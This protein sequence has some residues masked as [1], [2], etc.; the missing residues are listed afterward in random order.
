MV[1]ER[2][3]NYGLTKL[4]GNFQRLREGGCRNALQITEWALYGK[5]RGKW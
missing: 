3:V 2:Y 5:R 1:K 4:G